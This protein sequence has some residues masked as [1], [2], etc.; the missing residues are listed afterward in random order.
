MMLEKVSWLTNNSDIKNGQ[1][2]VTHNLNDID[3]FVGHETN[4]HHKM[5]G[6]IAYLIFYN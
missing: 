4:F 2:K 5:V 3:L 6:L 1:L